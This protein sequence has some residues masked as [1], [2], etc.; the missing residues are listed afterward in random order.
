[1]TDANNNT[2]TYK[3]DDK[4]RIYQVISPDTGTTTYSYDPRLL[5]DVG[6]HDALRYFLHCSMAAKPLDETMLRASERNML[7]LH[8]SN[9]R[10]ASLNYLKVSF[11]SILLVYGIVIVRDVAEF[12]FLDRVDLVPHEAGHMLFSWFGEFIIVLGGTIGQLFVPVAFVVYFTMRKEPFSSSVV[13]FWLGQ[14]FI[15]ISRYVKDAQV[16]DMPLVSVGGGGDT[17]HDWNY[18]LTKINLLRHDQVIGNAIL[19]LGLLVMLLSVILGFYY[20]V[21]REENES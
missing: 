9:V 13:L 11:S 7:N 10:G 8:T 17:I 21:N 18:I 5:G 2:T 16:M 20:S 4:G 19:G 12:R 1:M 14:N 6:S 3:Y 15:N